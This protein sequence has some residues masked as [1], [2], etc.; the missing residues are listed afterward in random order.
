VF[1]ERP[2]YLPGCKV[3][4][5]PALPTGQTAGTS[6]KTEVA[7]WRI[8][9]AEFIGLPGEVFPFTY[10]R[11]P[12][13]PAD[14]NYPRYALP[15]W[16]LPYMNAAYR[17]FDGLDNDMIGYIFPRGNDA[18]IPGDDPLRNPTASG[19]D[20][21]HCRHS[22]DSEAVSAKA[23]DKLGS[24]LVAILAANG[25]RE[26]VE[27]GRYVLRDGGLSR[28]PE[29]TTDTIKCTGP[30]TAFAAG[31]PAVAVWE[32]GRRVIAPPEWMDLLGRPQSTPNRNT[33]GYFDTT[34]HR[35]WLDVFADI[36]GQ[37]ASVTL[38]GSRDAGW[39]RR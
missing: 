18:G 15:P 1:A 24:A 28:N 39:R 6:I 12:V 17:F 31:G 11:G 3:A 32:P 16:P 10:F 21:F 38:R 19:T 27:Q 8:G 26:A 34:G 9:D 29:G 20:R 25:T 4:G 7:A 13:G 30:D 14:L 22:D 23:A 36:P 2:A 37:P 33:R 35:H 5:V